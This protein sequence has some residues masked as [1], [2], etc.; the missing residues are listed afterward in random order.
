MS[1]GLLVPG[2]A[3]D[4]ACCRDHRVYPC[5]GW[6]GRV[7]AAGDLYSVQQIIRSSDE[8]WCIFYFSSRY[9]PSELSVSSSVGFAPVLLPREHDNFEAG[10]LSFQDTGVESSGCV[11]QPQ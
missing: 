4:E 8:P 7:T 3:I 6:G 2:D 9:P 11:A 1:S 10:V 5:R